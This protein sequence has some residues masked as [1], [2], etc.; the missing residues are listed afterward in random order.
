MRFFLKVVFYLLSKHRH[1]SVVIP[2]WFWVK[3][4]QGRL[5]LWSY[6]L[7]DRP[8]AFVI[9]SEGQINIARGVNF[10]GSS[11]LMAL[12]GGRISIGEG[13]FFN[14]NCS[15]NAFEE[16]NIGKN[17]LFGEQVKIYDHNHK[18]R[19]PGQLIRKQGYSK[20]KITIGDNTW[21]G[22]NVVILKGANIGSNVVVGAGCIIDSSISDNSIVKNI[23][24]QSYTKYHLDN[25]STN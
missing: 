23:S 2:H 10:S 18:F 11:K 21:I 24:S 13:T 16:I 9:D 20:S 5:Q 3:Y 7:S 17:C 15:V 4:Y 6:K 12:Y 8:L 19:Q 25:S 22:S 14:N 1:Y